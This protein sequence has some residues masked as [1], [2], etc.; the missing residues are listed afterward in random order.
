ME[1]DLDE[2]VRGPTLDTLHN[3]TKDQLLLIAE[4][5]KVTVD[6]RV[7]RGTVEAE[8]LEALVQ[9]GIFPATVLP[10]SPVG[11]PSKASLKDD[12]VRL[13]EL[14]VELGRLALREKELHLEQRRLEIQA[15]LR[16]KELELGAESSQPK[17]NDFDVS[18]SV[19]K[20]MLCPWWT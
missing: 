11:S 7:K 10:K 6:K 18:R 3:C 14:E 12:P 16:L 17:S 13:K 1:F 19:R 2:F 15:E 8:L 5:F 9:I 20:G 4:H